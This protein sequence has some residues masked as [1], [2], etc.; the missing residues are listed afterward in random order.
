MKHIKYLPRTQSGHKTQGSGMFILKFVRDMYYSFSVQCIALRLFACMYSPAS[1][2]ER[3][4]PLSLSPHFPAFLRVYALPRL[5]PPPS[6]SHRHHCG[7]RR[8]ASNPP[9]PPPGTLP[10][11][12]RTR[13]S[14]TWKAVSGKR[15]G[16]EAHGKGVR[17]GLW[18]SCWEHLL[19][20]Q[21]LFLSFC[22][23]KPAALPSS[24][25][26]VC[27][28]CSLRLASR[29][30]GGGRGGQKTDARSL[31]YFSLSLSLCFSL[32]NT[33][34]AVNSRLLCWRCRRCHVLFSLVGSLFRSFVLMAFLLYATASCF[35]FLPRFLRL[36]WFNNDHRE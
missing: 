10:P 13:K 30:A 12:L 19:V 23:D 29:H 20:I 24:P 14:A 32:S 31:Q 27:A 1:P 33:R 7:G 6:P 17:A 2:C 22:C 35:L 18:L 25:S 16:G 5:F 15:G 8:L 3:N 4:V 11:A 28:V 21:H 26:M 36:T 34:G 9:L